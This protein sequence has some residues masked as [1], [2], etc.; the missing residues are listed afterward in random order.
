MATATRCRCPAGQLV[1]QPVEL[2]AAQADSI[3]RLA[4]ER[5]CLG[6]A[7]RTM[8]P[9]R[10]GDLLADADQAD[11]MRGHRLLKDHAD[12]APRTPRNSASLIASS[13][14]SSKCTDS[15]RACGG[16]QQPHDG[17]GRHGLSRSRRADQP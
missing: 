9:H 16:R 7:H 5:S 3:E 15:G 1:G 8:Q 11:S 6:R 14:R 10:L 4:R 17:E 13:S 12:A 2:D